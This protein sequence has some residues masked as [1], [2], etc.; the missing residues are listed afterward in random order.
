[1]SSIIILY[2]DKM[3]LHNILSIILIFSW[4]VAVG[5]AVF[6]LFN[7]FKQEDRLSLLCLAIF[8]T[9]MIYGNFSQPV[10]GGYDNKHDFASISVRLDQN[11]ALYSYKEVA[12][13][14]LKGVIDNISGNSLKAILY[15]N[16]L[17]PVFSMLLLY[18]AFRRAGAGKAGSLAG[19]AL[20]FFNFHT[21]LN[22]SSFSTTSSAFLAFS[23]AIAAILSAYGKKK[24]CESD[25]VWIFSATALVTMSRIEHIPALV[26]ISAALAYSAI[27]K[28]DPIL[29]NPNSLLV[30]FVGIAGIAVC[31]FFQL[32][33]TPQKLLHGISPVANFAMQMLAENMY[34][35]LSSNPA[36]AFPA[37]MEQS[38]AGSIYF[39]LTQTH[40]FRLLSPSLF[41]IGGFLL[42][43]FLS[44]PFICCIRQAIRREYSKT[45]TMI[46]ALGFVFVYFMTIYSWQDHYPLHFIRHRLF[47]MIPV[48]AIGAFSASHIYNYCTGRL[49]QSKT[50]M[51][52]II[53]AL[54]LSYCGI[55]LSV[56]GKLGNTLRSN[57]IEWDFL[58]KNQNTIR[59]NYQIATTVF[60][61]RNPFMRLYF[62]NGNEAGKPLL[63]YVSPEN[64]SFAEK[65]RNL[66]PDPF[67][68]PFITREFN[69][70][71]YT[72]DPLE[73]HDNI[74]TGIG[75][76]SLKEDN[77][78]VKK[79]IMSGLIALS[80]GNYVLAKKYA[81]SMNDI[82]ELSPHAH[83]LRLIA[84]SAADDSS[85]A[86]ME[87]EYFDST[88]LAL[89][90]RKG[91]EM[92]KKQFAMQKDAMSKTVR[93]S[94]LP[95]VYMSLDNIWYISSYPV[96][97]EV[98]TS[99][100]KDI[101]V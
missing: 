67:L 42:L 82:D 22:S 19:I 7:F 47:M 91:L 5:I 100:E 28:K 46:L 60:N 3:L 99:D 16:R 38:G 10:R 81:E 77:A 29:K 84:F 23:L 96:N 98:S 20:I 4:P 65:P 55:N 35:L 73:S 44:I 11:L 70:R 72:T 61:N 31:M 74:R 1:M 30:S 41:G 32:S 62:S 15:A 39:E 66:K 78:A 13:V 79:A 88:L 75:F 25:I 101:K 51:S 40:P 43:A 86:D 49:R 8:A 83:F 26:L 50:A 33:F 71:F 89:Y 6:S 52:A 85:E 92:S 93:D 53:I 56:A 18:A 95:N 58:L 2:N 68:K 57:D 24:I 37:L 90:D 45:N 94:L 17:L 87:M 34:I 64:Y 14:L 80:D 27:R 21:F 54:C 76:Y 9:I 48:A 69:H 59:G 36:G 63:Y 97:N 12:P